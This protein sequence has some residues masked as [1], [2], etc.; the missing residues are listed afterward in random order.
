MFCAYAYG[1][2]IRIT[3]KYCVVLQKIHAIVLIT[4]ITLK[5]LHKKA[6]GIFSI[7][8]VD[9]SQFYTLE[10]SFLQPDGG[11]D[12]ILQPRIYTCQLGEHQLK[13]D[14]TPFQTYEVTGVTGHWGV[15]FH[16]GNWNKDSDGCI[17]VGSNIDLTG[18][19]PMITH[20]EIAFKSFMTLMNNVDSFTLNVM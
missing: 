3:I 20:S 15:L 18:V 11:Y 4:M 8:F 13:H 9:G 5:R 16:V 14:P 7:L 2:V 6:E 1:K 10:H 17:L 19:P 12:A